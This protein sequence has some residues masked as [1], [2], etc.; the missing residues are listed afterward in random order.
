LH[1]YPTIL[2]SKFKTS[3]WQLH[4]HLTQ[5]FAVSGSK[6]NHIYQACTRYTNRVWLYQYRR[7]A[8]NAPSAL[9]GWFWMTD[10]ITDWLMEC[11]S[12]C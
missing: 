1:N 10:A 5:V 8:L 6:I 3:I 2:T 4:P 7:Q 11:L 9:Q 12:K